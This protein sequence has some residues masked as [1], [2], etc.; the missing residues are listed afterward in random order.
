V[1]EVVVLGSGTVAPSARRNSAGYWVEAGPVRLLMDCGA[2]TTHRLAACN[3]D[4]PRTTHV[5]LSHFHIDHWGELPAF[6]FA[7]QY[8]T[9]PPRQE[10]LVLIGPAGIRNRMTMLAAALGDWVLD[11]G[12]PL[13]IREIVPGGEIDLGAGVTLRATKTPH[14]PE[15]L[16]Y[17]VQHAGN[18]LVYSGDTG[19]SE[20]VAAFAKGCDLL[21]I[22]CSLPD[23][24]P[25]TIHLTPTEAGRMAKLAGAR[26]VVLS[27]FYPQIEGTNPA[28]VAARVSGG[29]VVAANDGDRFTTGA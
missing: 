1:I 5:A 2:G 15:S 24:Q 22:E 19:Y 12:Y 29:E 18:R 3:L 16:A 10:P 25:M 23:A 21:I 14:T 11:A 4:W 20:S 8:G 7:Q 9:L 13:D 6:L 17:S 28:E 27:H 26:R